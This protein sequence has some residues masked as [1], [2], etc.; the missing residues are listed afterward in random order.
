MIHIH[1]DFLSNYLLDATKI[2]AFILIAKS[3]GDTTLSGPT[4]AANAMNV[5]FRLVRKI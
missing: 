5:N 4:S 1:C 3:D 2:L